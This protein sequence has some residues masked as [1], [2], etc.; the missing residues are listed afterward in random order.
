MNN[1]HN[2]GRICHHEDRKVLYESLTIGAVDDEDG[3]DDVNANDKCRRRNFYQV[4]CRLALPSFFADG[5]QGDGVKTRQGGGGIK[6]GEGETLEGEISSWEKLSNKEKGGL[7][8]D[9]SAWNDKE[10][11]EEANHQLNQPNEFGHQD[12]IHREERR[13]EVKRRELKKPTDSLSNV[14]KTDDGWSWI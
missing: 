14:D 2:Q 10:G 6:T 12:P 13:E 9:G 1:C 3:G 8:I 7:Q 11:Y 5:Q 4:C